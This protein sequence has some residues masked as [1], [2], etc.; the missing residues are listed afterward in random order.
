MGSVAYMSPEQLSGKELD[1]SS[2]LFSFGVVLYE[3]MTGVLPFRGE[4]TG[5]IFDSILNRAPVPAVRVN[6]DV[7]PDLERLINKCL[8]KDRELRY[9]HASEVRADL[10]RL[11]RD[12]DSSRIVHSTKRDAVGSR[13]EH[14]TV[15]VSAALAVVFV[16]ILAG[17]LYYRSRSPKP[18]SDKHTIVLADFANSTEDGVFDDTLKTALAVSLRQS[19]FLSV[20]P[21]SQVAKTLQQMT[22]PT[23]M[24]LTPEVS[25]ELCQR[26]G[27][28]VYL[29]GSIGSLGSEYVLELSQTPFHP[30]VLN[31]LIQRTISPS[32][33]LMIIRGA[34][35]R[36]FCH[37]RGRGFESRRPRHSLQSVAVPINRRSGVLGDNKEGN[38][39]C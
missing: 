26:S 25:R 33:Q 1:A 6:P 34:A 3:M 23:T 35:R 21:D 15:G 17:G 11:K 38:A 12:K 19:P 28:K 7:P 10:Q 39:L 32:C 16:G 2:D 27:S 22:R 8:E 20:L 4:T 9:Q 18:L 36:V 37:G 13:R 24:K 31:C 5:V 30:S 29:A 14:R